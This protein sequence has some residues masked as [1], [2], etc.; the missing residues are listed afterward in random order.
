M[1]PEPLRRFDAAELRRFLASVDTFL[2]RPVRVILVGGSALA[3]GYQVGVGT[4]DID[5]W[6]TDLGIIGPAVKRAGPGLTAAG[7]DGGRARAV[8]G[9]QGQGCTDSQAAGE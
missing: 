5:T 1:S 7:V 3:L 9:G 8:T 4:M 6:E 2:D